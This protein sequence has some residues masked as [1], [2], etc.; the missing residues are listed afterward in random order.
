VRLQG[1]VKGKSYYPY[2]WVEQAK[3]VGHIAAAGEPWAGGLAKV[4]N[5]GKRGP[6]AR[7]EFLAGG[8][9]AG[10]PDLLVD[11]YALRRVTGPVSL[12]APALID[13]DLRITP[14]IWFG[15]RIE[16][17]RQRGAYTWTERGL[18]DA[19]PA[20]QREWIDRLRARGYAAVVAF[21]WEEGV[22]IFEAYRRG[23]L[24]LPAGHWYETHE[25]AL[26]C[27]K[28]LL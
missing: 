12:R 5:E 26:A 23:R 3:V 2:E 28:E 8:G 11:A 4:P 27:D 13:G 9:K 24:V 17:K 14:P 6:Q 16:M 18:W 10:Y 7:R 22:A 20:A 25:Q 1:T 15:L 21:G 19:V